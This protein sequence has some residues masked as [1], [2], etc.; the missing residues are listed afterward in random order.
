MIKHPGLIFYLVEDLYNYSIDLNNFICLINM[1]WDSIFILINFFEKTHKKKDLHYLLNSRLRNEKKKLILN[2]DINQGEKCKNCADFRP[3]IILQN[4]G[5]G[6]FLVKKFYEKYQP[7]VTLG[8]LS[9][10]YEKTTNPEKLNYRIFIQINKIRKIK[11]FYEIINQY[12]EQIIDSDIRLTNN[13]YSCKNI[14]PWMLM[15]NSKKTFD[16]IHKIKPLTEPFITIKYFEPIFIHQ[17]PEEIMNIK[18]WT[19]NS[20]KNLDS[21]SI[22]P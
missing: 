3:W 17:I 12:R 7:W 15:N 16:L 14:Y 22:Y 5:E 1:M 18:S 11:Q 10:V 20:E 4:S 9:N 2:Y 13:C 19:V 21:I 6:L 8:I